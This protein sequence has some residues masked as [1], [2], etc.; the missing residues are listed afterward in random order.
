MGKNGL[1]EVQQA[2]VDHDDGPAA[3]FAVAG[4]GK[5]FTVVNYIA[6]KIQEQNIEPRKI[7]ATTF[8]RDAAREMNDR[9]KSMGVDTDSRDGMRV[10]TF[11]SV[12]LEIL[13]DGSPWESC[14]VDAKDTMRLQLKILLGYQGMDWKGADVTN[15]NSFIGRCKNEMIGPEDAHTAF[16]ILGMRVDPRY[17]EAYRRYEAERETRGLITFDDMLYLSVRHLREDAA[18]RD[19]WQSRF[20]HVVVDEFQDSNTAQYELV[21]IL[22]TGS[23]SLL[24]VG[25]DD[26]LVYSWRGSKSEYTL[27]FEQEHGAKIYR[28][29]KNYRSAPEILA[30]ANRVI[31]N[32]DP[33]R[34]KKENVAT[35]ESNGEKIRVF[36]CENTDD[37]ADQIVADI[38]ERR[39]GGSEWKDHTI[40]YRTNAQSRALEEKMISAKIPHVVV[41]GV[42]FWRRREIA[43]MLAYLKLIEDSS[44]DEAFKRCVRA[45]FRYIGKVTIEAMEN[46]ASRS[47]TSLFDVA[48]SASLI[49]IARSRQADSIALFAQQ[50]RRIKDEVEESR[51]VKKELDVDEMGPSTVISRVLQ[52]TQYLDWIEKDEGSD[53]A[54]NSRTANVKE[55][56]RTADRFSTIRE[57]LDYVE[58]TERQKRKKKGEEVD[59]VRLM[60]IHKSKGLE[61]P[62]VYV[63]GCSDG[64]LPHAMTVDEQE[65]R[66]LF[67][68]ATTRARDSLIYTWPRTFARANGEQYDVEPSPFLFEAGAMVDE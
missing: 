52:A 38:L 68:V 13:R 23:K 67:Y 17:V 53:S 5:T 40:L 47:G 9:L 61:F 20:D 39:E 3:M 4:S 37:E 10:G 29:E 2:V 60:T 34:V 62:V 50:V 48:E 42:G 16:E 32:N 25:D 22:S 30:A 27:N 21:K 45:P 63:A 31:A 66:R 46:E 19:R 12:C 59:A 36:H 55:L 41:G 64:I 49:R 33:N 7:L 6:R 24:V 44:D 54:E 14:E 18:A 11:H 56:V 65:E 28:V 51:Q 58:E 15:V 57:L 26:Q 8:T 43:D 35:R 1:N